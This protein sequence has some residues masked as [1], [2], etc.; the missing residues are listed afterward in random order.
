MTKLALLSMGACL[1]IGSAGCGGGKE[2][3][4]YTGVQLM[5]GLDGGLGLQ[6]RLNSPV[7]RDVYDGSIPEEVYD[8]P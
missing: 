1:L 4:E 2:L 7:L 6:D 8:T 5:P 3:P